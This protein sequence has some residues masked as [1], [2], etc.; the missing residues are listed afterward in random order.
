MPQVRK[1]L[2]SFRWG[3]H[4][5]AI[6]DKMARFLRRRL[7]F[8]SLEISP[9]CPRLRLLRQGPDYRSCEAGVF[10]NLNRGQLLGAD[11]HTSNDRN[12][13]GSSQG[14]ILKEPGSA[15]DN[16]AEALSNATNCS[17]RI[18]GAFRSVACAVVAGTFLMSC[19][20]ERP[21]QVLARE[22]GELCAINPERICVRPYGDQ[23]AAAYIVALYTGGHGYDPRPND[24]R[25]LT[26]WARRKGL[27]LQTAP[28]A[29]CMSGNELDV[30]KAAALACAIPTSALYVE[31]RRRSWWR[32]STTITSAGVRE[33]AHPAASSCINSWAE[34]RGFYHQRQL[35]LH[36]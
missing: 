3:S 29:P 13:G 1:L 34:S 9:I 17:V 31:Q 10:S 23:M 7:A 25:C 14:Q 2:S 36:N 24:L 33:D 16:I 27:N 30:A 19:A 21:E 11:K 8:G 26:K 12:G 28:V 35:R 18:F 5:H 20:S 32:S 22:A 4:R 15:Q 6:A